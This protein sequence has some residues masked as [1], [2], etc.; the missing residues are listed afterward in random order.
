MWHE[1]ISTN[2]ELRNRPTDFDCFVIYF[3]RSRLNSQHSAHHSQS[4]RQNIFF[5]C[6]NFEKRRTKKKS[7]LRRNWNCMSIIVAKSMCRKSAWCKRIAIICSDSYIS[8]VLIRMMNWSHWCWIPWKWNEFDL[9]GRKTVF[10]NT[11][12]ISL[13]WP[14]DW[15]DTDSHLLYWFVLTNHYSG[16]YAY[17][18]LCKLH[19]A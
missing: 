19:R 8:C 11:R 10:G 7:Y 4:A 9:N 1:Y 15:N 12:N 14:M 17:M 13:L 18:L 16:S 3:S 6:C 2:L 5:I